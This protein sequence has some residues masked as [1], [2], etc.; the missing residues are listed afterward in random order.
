MSKF[1]FKST[2]IIDSATDYITGLDGLDGVDGVDEIIEE[3]YSPLTDDADTDDEIITKC[4][5][6]AAIEERIPAKFRWN[7]QRQKAALLLAEGHTLAETAAEV[8]V[9]PRHI[10]TWKEN[11]EFLAEV[12]RLTFLTGIVTKAERIRLI[13]RFV[14]SKI[15][16]NGILQS[17]KDVFEWIKL[18]RSEVSSME[19]A[20]MMA[21]IISAAADE[22]GIKIEIGKIG[23]HAEKKEAR[24]TSDIEQY[25]DQVS[26]V[27]W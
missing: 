16:E 17:K 23:G 1:E 4:S 12:D 18:L 5:A 15:D 27:E 2:M 21:Q 3:I 22:A 8:G 6:I 20:A 9:S 14:R 7:E 19:F 26:E 24:E 11:L 13:K 10:S 25:Y